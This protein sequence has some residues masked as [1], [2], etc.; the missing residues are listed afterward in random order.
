MP[1]SLQ[2][3]LLRFLQE[4]TIER[5]GGR[6]E[7]AVDVRVVCATNKNLQTMVQEGSFREDLF[8]R[9]CEVTIEIPPLRGSQGD[10]GLLARH[11]RRRF[12]EQ[13]NPTIRG[14]TPDA[15]EAI[16]RYRWPG[17]IREMEN[18]I[19]LAVIMSDGKYIY[20]DDL[21]L[22]CGDELSLNLRHVRQ[23]A[24]R[25]AILQAVAITDN[26]I[27]AAAQ[28][29]GLSCSPFYDLTKKHDILLPSHA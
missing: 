26:N 8:Y 12:L 27:S 4:R 15:V 29:L 18:K 11:F 7:I 3:K 22:A 24:Q 28:L 5:L 6:T 25:H 23:E 1:L 13:H 2:A 17:N 20:R 10:K 16:E 19:K 14:F 9:I 21:D